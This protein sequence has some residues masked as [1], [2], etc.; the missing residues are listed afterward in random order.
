MNRTVRRLALFP[1]IA[2]LAVVVGACGSQGVDLPANE[3]SPEIKNGAKLF[4]QRCSG[5]HTISVAGT[6]GSA[7]SAK[8]KEYKNGPNFDVRKV[9]YEDVLY[10]I[11]NGGFSS[12]PMPQNI[13][14]GQDAKDIARFLAKY[15]KTASQ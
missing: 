13:V 15:S 1:A 5:C 12:G 4:A 9:S 6:H 11:E 2:I 7:I 14:V 8:T 3:T 10:A